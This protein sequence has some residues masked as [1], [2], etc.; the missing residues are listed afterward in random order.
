M[1]GRQVIDSLYKTQR[2]LFN[3][4]IL[5]LLSCHKDELLNKDNLFPEKLIE[6]FCAVVQ[7]SKYN[8]LFILLEMGKIKV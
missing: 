2:C 5:S 3:L 7:F 6:N 1:V 4:L 8:E